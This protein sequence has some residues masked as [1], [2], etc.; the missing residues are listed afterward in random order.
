[1]KEVFIILL[2]NT[3]KYHNLQ[4]YLQ[5]SKIQ[6]KIPLAFC[7]GSQAFRVGLQKYII[8]AAL[9]N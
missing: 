5:Q 1:M 3:C 8:S 2:N 4:Y 9:Y 7:Q 6:L